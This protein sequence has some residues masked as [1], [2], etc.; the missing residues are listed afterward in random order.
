LLVFKGMLIGH[1]TWTNT[2][3]RGI[4]ALVFKSYKHHSRT[5]NIKKQNNVSRFFACN[6]L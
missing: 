4:S 6:S 3:I 2:H 1:N 5:Q